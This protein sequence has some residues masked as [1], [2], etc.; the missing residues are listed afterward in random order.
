[1]WNLSTTGVTPPTHQDAKELAYTNTQ[2]ILDIVI[3]M[4]S[5]LVFVGTVLLTYFLDD[6]GLK[7]LKQSAKEEA[8]IAL[9]EADKNYL[10]YLTER[11][12]LSSA[13]GHT[14]TPGYEVTTSTGADS[15]RRRPKH[16]PRRRACSESQTGLRSS[17]LSSETQ[18]ILESLLLSAG[19]SVTQGSQQRRAL[20]NLASAYRRKPESTRLRM[21]PSR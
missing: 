21:L 6:P 10:S 9:S 8:P 12:L 2:L 17:P 5:M 1:M 4:L 16:E 19:H 7:K 3:S 14:F 13:K 15:D 11:K 18:V 20:A